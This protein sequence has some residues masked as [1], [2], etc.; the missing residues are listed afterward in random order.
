MTDWSIARVPPHEQDT[1]ARHLKVLQCLSHQEL[2][3]SFRRRGQE[4]NAMTNSSNL[5]RI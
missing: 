5:D 4:R 3:V 1:R 2:S